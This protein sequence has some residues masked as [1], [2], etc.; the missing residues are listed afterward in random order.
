[1]R[2]EREEVA[3]VPASTD[4]ST[5]RPPSYARDELLARSI[6]F[7]FAVALGL[8]LLPLQGNPIDWSLL[9][10]A[11]AAITCV[12]AMG[13]AIAF[14][15][16]LPTWWLRLIPYLFLLSVVLLRAATGGPRSGYVALLYL[17]PFWVALTD[18]RRQ[19]LCVTFAM[20][21]AQAAQAA[22]WGDLLS[23]TVVRGALMN[24]V[25]VGIMSLAV[26]ANVSAVHRA[27][28]RLRAEADARSRANA[29][30]EATNEALARS[31]HDLEQ[32]AY[33]SSHD[34]QEPLRMIRSFTQLFMQRKG[35]TLD[36]EGRELL[37]FVIDGSERAQ[38]LVSDL[39]EFARVGTEDAPRTRVDLAAV[40]LRARTELAAQL[41]AAGGRIEVAP[42]LP[43]VLGDPAQLERVLV[44]L[45]GNA[46]KYRAP[47][48]PPTVRID[49]HLADGH[50][51][52]DVADNGI[53]FDEEQAGRIFQMFQRLRPRGEYDG[54]GIGLAICARIV[55]RHG[56]TITARST[57]GAGSTFTF[58]LEAAA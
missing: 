52:V 7:A 20:F 17:A 14:R 39:L 56:G 8:A 34:L 46:I 54:T 9:V 16:S 35:S 1:V 15:P 12:L 50:V 18:T 19:V 55:E 4:P 45:L 28:A 2:S 5:R 33:V 27:K 49:A 22:V 32:F 58:T 38:A 25:V 36:D 57:P 26:Q 13:L 3:T 47:E 41:D 48:R 23:A 24:T 40:A 53:G 30:L 43:P 29:Q 37:G 6:P 42:D 31:N 11:V 51:V 10:P 21:V 44:N